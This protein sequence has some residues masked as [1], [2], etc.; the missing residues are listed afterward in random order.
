[1][2]TLNY[3][4][5]FTRTVFI[6]FVRAIGIY[7][8]ITLPALAALPAMYATSAVYALSFGW[9][10]GILF[11]FFFYLLRKMRMGW[12]TGTGFLYAAVAI[13]VLV[14]FQMMEI[15]G[16][17]DHI[18]QSG[19]FLMFPAA[20]VISGWISLAV[21]RHKIKIFFVPV[22]SGF[23]EAVFNSSTPEDTI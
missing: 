19:A 10:A 22:D 4:V 12:V 16:V 14:A 7:L 11:L 3:K 13:A 18:W 21:S 20:A 15:M 17:Q 9:I 1:M 23:Y 2:N 6:L 8:L 5:L